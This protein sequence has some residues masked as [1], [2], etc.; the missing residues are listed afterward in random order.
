MVFAMAKIPPT[1]PK[2]SRSTTF[3]WSFHLVGM[4]QARIAAAMKGAKYNQAK[5]P[6]FPVH[7]LGQTVLRMWSL[8]KSIATAARAAG[9]VRR[10][11]DENRTLEQDVGKAKAALR[12]V[13]KRL[14]VLEKDRQAPKARVREIESLRG[15]IGTLRQERE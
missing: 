15:E 12:A 13:E 8:I 14:V 10:L 6:I 9:L 2:D 7:Q 4:I 3:S 5:S 11:R 1:R